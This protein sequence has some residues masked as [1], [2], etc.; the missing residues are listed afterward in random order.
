MVCS[1]RSYLSRLIRTVV[2][3]FA[4]GAGAQNPPATI[5]V[6]VNLN[7]RPINPNIYGVA[8]ATT[9]QLNDLNSPLNRNGGNNTSRY[10][11]QLNADNRANDWYFESIPEPSAVAGERGDTFIANAKAANAQAMLTIPTLDWIAKLG[12]NRGKLASFSIAKYGAQ[13]GNDWQWFADAGNGIRSGGGYVTGNNPNDANV[14]SNSTVQQSWAQ[15]LVNRWGANSNGGL[16]YYILDNE[17]SIWH[18]THRDVHSTGATMDEIKNKIIDFAG[19][20]KIVDPSALV[21]GPEEWGWSGYTLSGYD[22]QYGSLHGWSNLPDRVAH[23]GWDYLPWL[24]DQLRQNDLA[25]GKRLLDIFTV[26]YY[27][28][29]GEFSDDTSTVMQLRRNRSTRSLWDPNYIDESWIN[30][31]VKLVPRLR[32]WVNAYYPGTLTGITEYNWGAENHINGAT[33]QADIYGIFGREGLDMAARWTTPDASTPTYKAMRLYR[34][35]DGNKSTFGDV[36]VAATAANPDNVTVFAAERSADGALTIMAISKYLSGTT[37]VTLNL[38]NFPHNGSAHVWQLGATN[39]IN[40]LGDV[41]F[42]GGSFNYTLPAQSITLF[43][44]PA[45]SG[46]QTPVAVMSAQPGSGTAPLNVAFTG[47]SSTDGDGSIIAYV[48]NFGDGATAS[49]S[50][51][52]HLYSAP[53]SYLA[54]LTVTDNQGATNSTTTTIQVNASLPSAPSNLTASTISRSQINLSWSD[55]AN[56][57]TGFKIE[58]CTGATCTNFAQIAAVGANLKTFANSGLKR[59][60]AYRYRVRAYN[61]VADSAYSNIAGAITAR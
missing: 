49:G 4:L 37:A 17:P 6:D 59:N 54:R 40:H 39:A 14:A 9:A 55:N 36:S 60:T 43:V 53:G 35:Y 8:H 5:N 45:A 1:S 46:N 22:Q 25:T 16:R 20:L 48:W 34:N 28:Q 23:G 51:A 21:V 27:P 24:L 7:R 52:N 29:G 32:D 26:H 38:A 31:R 15:H 56:N 12:A 44:L 42:I 11:W 50:T 41:N 10:N 2:I 13:T 19:K 61:G 57:E 33:A 30:D 47:S 3:F 18:A 58:R